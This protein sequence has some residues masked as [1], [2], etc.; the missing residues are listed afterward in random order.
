M[1]STIITSDL[2]PGLLAFSITPSSPHPLIVATG[3]EAIINAIHFTSSTGDRALLIKRSTDPKPITLYRVNS[4]P[5]G[6]FAGPLLIPGPATVELQTSH[7]VDVVGTVVK[8]DDLWFNSRS[9]DAHIEEEE[10]GMALEDEEEGV[11]TEVMKDEGIEPPARPQQDSKE[12]KKRKKKKRKEEA[13]RKQSELRDAL[14]RNRPSSSG[15]DDLDATAGKKK[16]KKKKPAAP[17]VLRSRT[18]KG[19]VVVSDTIIG[20]STI[21]LIPECNSSS[22]L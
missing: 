10:E 17:A 14:K 4:K 19:K 9:D 1:S 12:E 3:S 20:E 6:V 18:L 2:S 8:V 13:E 7:D 11:T 21:S 5:Y 22:I 15:D 16:K